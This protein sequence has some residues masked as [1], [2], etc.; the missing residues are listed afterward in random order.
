MSTSD[1]RVRFAACWIG[2]V[3]LLAIAGAAPG[4]EEDV[5]L[6]DEIILK[7]GPPR[8]RVKILEDTWQGVKYRMGKRLM[9]QTVPVNNVASVRYAEQ[10]GR[11]ADFAEYATTKRFYSK[12]IIYFNKKLER[13]QGEPW[14][15]QYIF[16][17][18]GYA[19]LQRGDTAKDYEEA[20]KNFEMLKS[21]PYKDSRFI[22]QAYKGIGDS[23]YSEN[24]YDEAIDAYKKARKKFVAMAQKAGSDPVQR[25]CQWWAHKSEYARI[26]VVEETDPETA[27]SQYDRLASKARNFPDIVSL[28]RAGVGRSLIKTKQYPRAIK[29]FEA[30]IE[31]A[32]NSGED[33]ALSGA[34]VGLGDCYYA[35]KDY[36]RARYNYLRVIVLYFQDEQYLMQAHYFAGRCYEKL[37]EDRREP[38]A[39]KWACRHFRILVERYGKGGFTKLA[40]KRLAELGCAAGVKKEAGGE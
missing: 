6:D 14:R 38:D 11:W 2:A 1:P 31:E 8:I 13:L 22:F 24:R 32:R 25:Y 21:G 17:Y 15:G 40:E 39:K 4:Q 18:L 23:Y 7:N 33:A 12:A 35:N 29:R 34:Y 19:H 20:R 10:P 9:P 36:I 5:Q 28:C 37:A 30:M 26:R 27:K 3:L 16:F